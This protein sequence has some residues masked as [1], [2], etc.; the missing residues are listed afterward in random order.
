MVNL[1]SYLPLKRIIAEDKPTLVSGDEKLFAARL[2][3][4]QRNTEEELL[5]IA[6]IRQQVAH[7]LRTLPPEDFQRRGIHSEYGPIVLDAMI[8]RITDH[9]PHHVRF[10]E[11]KQEALGLAKA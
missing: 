3:Y 1:G 8:E 9:I 10:I 6:L 7:I 2:A 4:H 5:L 11:Q